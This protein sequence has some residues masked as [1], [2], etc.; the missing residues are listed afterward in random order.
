MMF[1]ELNLCSF[2][3]FEC[4]VLLD[5]AD[6]NTSNNAFTRNIRTLKFCCIPD[7]EKYSLE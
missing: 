6:M 1:S 3:L 4:I 5:A 2:R 7:Q